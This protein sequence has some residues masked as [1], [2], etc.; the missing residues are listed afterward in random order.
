MTERD[1]FI[2]M[3]NY[4]EAKVEDNSNKEASS[5]VE[6]DVSKSVNEGEERNA[7]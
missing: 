3:L 6:N 4:E 5:T 7:A 1:A 2:T